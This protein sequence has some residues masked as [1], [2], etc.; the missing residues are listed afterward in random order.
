MEIDT[1]KPYTQ[2]PYTDIHICVHHDKIK[3]HTKY[4]HNALFYAFSL[5]Y[6]KHRLPDKNDVHV[7]CIICMKDISPV[8]VKCTFTMIL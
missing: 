3:Q 5:L 8:S 7:R 1:T 4:D 6:H 2:S